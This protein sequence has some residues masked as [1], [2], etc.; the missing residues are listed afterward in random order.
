MA[1]HSLMQWISRSSLGSG[2]IPASLCELSLLRDLS[3]QVNQLTGVCTGCLL[4]PSPPAVACFICVC[5]DCCCHWMHPGRIPEEISRLVSLR[6]LCFNVN[7]LTGPIP[8]V[9]PAGCQVIALSRNQLSGS[10]VRNNICRNPL[11]HSAHINLWICR[12]CSCRHE[13][14]DRAEHGV[15]VR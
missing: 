10:K 4:L 7:R 1:L 15:S 5:Y 12:P 6:Q 13:Y 14:L 3:M 2:P 9:L 11:N 8:E